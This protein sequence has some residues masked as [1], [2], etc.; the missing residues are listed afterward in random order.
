MLLLL[1]LSINLFYFYQKIY[2][3]EII[4]ERTETTKSLRGFV[5]NNL[6]REAS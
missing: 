4:Y 5:G 2:L 3:T 1:R 6:S